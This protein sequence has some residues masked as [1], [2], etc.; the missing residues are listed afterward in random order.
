MATTSNN[1]LFLEGQSITRPPMFNGANYVSCKDRMEIFLQFIDIELWYIVNEGPYE[2]SIIDE[3]NGEKRSKTRF[4][5]SPQDNVNLT[6]NAKAVNII[7]NALDANESTRVRGCKTAKEIW[8]KLREIHEGSDNVR[9]QKK[10]LLVTKY[11][12]FRMEPHE[13]R[14]K[15]YCRFNDIIKDLEVLNKHYSLGEKNRIS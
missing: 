15:M 2:A 5:L 12:S 10:A 4:E 1:A 14:D 6:L 9:E 8:D 11:E 3:I 13:N 7:Y